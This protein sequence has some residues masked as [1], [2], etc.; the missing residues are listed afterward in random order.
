MGFTLLVKPC[1]SGKTGLVIDK[2][3]KILSSGKKNINVIFCDNSLLQ[4]NQTYTRVDGTLENSKTLC[5]SSKKGSLDNILSGIVFDDVSNIVSCANKTQFGNIT[6]LL[7]KFMQKELKYNFNIWIDEADRTVAGN[8]FDTVQSWDEYKRVKSITLITATPEK[9]LKKYGEMCIMEIQS[10]YNR[11]TYQRLSECDF[12]PI[13]IEDA[14]MIA[15]VLPE[16]ETE[17]KIKPSGKKIST[18][19]YARACL[20]QSTLKKGQV[21]FVPAD[22]G[23]NSHILMKDILISNG[24][25]VLVIN[26]DG[27]YLYSVKKK[28]EERCDI[29]E[30]KSVDI[31]KEL[32]AWV[33]EVYKSK[34]LSK[35]KFAITGYL[36]IGRGITISS[37]KMMLSHAILPPKVSDKS[38]LYQL[39]GRLSGN[40]KK[41]DNYKLTTVYGTEKVYNTACQ[42][43]DAVINLGE[44]SYGKNKKVGLSDYRKGSPPYNPPAAYVEEIEKKKK[45]EKKIEKKKKVEKKDVKKKKRE[46]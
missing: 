38:N 3:A 43:E 18:C 7:D 42:M 45:V 46:D 15:S 19:D 1:Q 13:S 35:K 2:I 5:M 27:K 37:P 34:K 22:S 25:N 9:I 23:K 28:E 33:A 14:T 32:S 39:I 6:K 12:T 20:E 16:V 17:A 8:L 30:I 41:F 31:E 36:C 11:K 4:T 21:W 24:F 44:D 40:T 10:A 29:T 26:G